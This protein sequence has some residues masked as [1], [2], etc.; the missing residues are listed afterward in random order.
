MQIFIR[1]VDGTT[2]TL[3][4]DPYTDILEIK[5]KIQFR[6]GTLIGVQR[7]SCGSKILEE[8]NS[9]A[10]YNVPKEATIHVITRVR[11]D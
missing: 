3:E 2:I 10:F 9:L 7:L 4:V 8:G 11:G 1:G 6:L 5:E